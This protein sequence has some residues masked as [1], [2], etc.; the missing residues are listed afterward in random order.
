MLRN[1]GLT[2]Q[3]WRVLRVLAA[4]QDGEI[5]ATTLAHQ[6]LLLAPSLSRIL[7]FLERRGYIMRVADPQDQRR[8]TFT[9]TEAGQRK[10]QEV[11]PDSELQYATI[12]SQFG[13]DNL[14]ALYKLLGEFESALT[15]EADNH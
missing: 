2:E 4:R 7:R 8:A 9:L 12:E 3:Q 11:A 6:A 13:K 10:F 14:D 1:H 15:G 5:D